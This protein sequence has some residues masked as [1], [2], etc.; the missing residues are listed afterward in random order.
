MPRHLLDKSQCNGFHGPRLLRQTRDRCVWQEGHHRCKEKAAT[1]NKGPALKAAK[2]LTRK[3]KAAVD[4][5]KKKEMEKVEA[6]AAKTKE[7]ANAKKNKKAGPFKK[8]P[9]DSSFES[10][11]DSG[12]CGKVR[13]KQY[14]PSASCYVVEGLVSDRVSRDYF[15]GV[16]VSIGNF[17]VFGPPN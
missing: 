6:N 9:K 8:G 16:G 5:A 4:A 14:G 3:G 11:G 10:I 15:Y 2:K 1:A 13:A 7:Y 12:V 17:E